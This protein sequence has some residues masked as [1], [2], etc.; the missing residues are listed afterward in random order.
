MYK[1]CNLVM[2]PSNEKAHFGDIILTPDTKKLLIFR[3][4]NC[5]E[6]AQHLYITSDEEIK[7]KDWMYSKM[8]GHPIQWDGD[9]SETKNPKEYGYSKIIATTNKSITV[10]GYD[11]SDEE[12]IVKCYLPQP[13]KEFI[14]AYIKA[15]NTR[16][17]IKEVMVEYNEMLQVRH[18]VEWYDLPNQT[19]GNDIN[20]IYQK[21]LRLKINPDNTINIKP[22]K[23]SWNRSEVVELL[24]KALIYGNQYYS[25]ELGDKDV[26]NWIEENL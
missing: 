22:I 7:S 14:E 17:S 18:G 11:S 20:N 6:V 5:T 15:Y 26:S 1:T 8:D 10:D 4:R 24:I 23:D 13:S 9:L 21:V 2:L 16:N 19:Q 25:D 3:H 12:S